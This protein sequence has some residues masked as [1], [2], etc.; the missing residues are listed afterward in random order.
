MHN[1]PSVWEGFGPWRVSREFY[2]EPLEI[3]LILVFFALLFGLLIGFTLTQSIRYRNRKERLET[4][5][6]RTALK[7]YNLTP[8][9]ERTL[10]AMQRYLPRGEGGA[11]LLSSL[12]LFRYCEERLIR[13]TPFPP[14]RTLAALRVK[15]GFTTYPAGRRIKATSEIPS[16]TRIV[17][18]NQSDA[19]FS[20]ILI[21]IREHDLVVRLVEGEYPPIGAPV[22]A[23][24]TTREGRYA[25][26]TGVTYC[27]KPYVYLEHAPIGE[28]TQQRK[29]LRHELFEPVSVQ[30]AGSSGRRFR[31]TLI[32]IG[33]G[34]C[35]LVNSEKRLSPGTRVEL[36]IEGDVPFS[37]LG[38][39]IRISR[40]GG[41]AHLQFEI[42]REPERDRLIRYI[43]RVS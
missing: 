24:F 15:L 19:R 37:L 3:V 43:R 23:S 1:A 7:R 20:G 4:R 8:G 40:N 35:S 39:V 13:G 6:Y 36:A 9:E 33:G 41:V 5:R 42:G 38:R 25:F 14:M 31:T 27:E 12:D 26:D 16:G 18:R 28:H 21:R 10:E 34:G 11:E 17:F 30:D 29:F 22:E 2:P 32:E